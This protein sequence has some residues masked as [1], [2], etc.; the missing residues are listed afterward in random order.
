MTKIK[1]TII[2]GIGGFYYV[3]DAQGVVHECKAC[4]RFRKEN[5][6]P[7]VGDVVEFQ[8]QNNLEYGFV[9][10][11]LP[12]KNQ[13]LRPEVANIDLLMI[14]VSASTPHVDFTLCDKLLIQAEKAGI[15]Q[16]LCINKMETDKKTV[17]EMQKQYAAYDQIAVSAHERLG[18]EQFREAVRG[19][20]VCLTGQSAVGKSSIINVLD[21]SLGLQVGGLSKKTARGRH[22]TR[23]TEL[24]PISKLDALVFDTP[25]F[26]ILDVSDIPKEELGWY[27]KEFE[28]YGGH[29]KFAS[30]V[31]NK[32][33]GCAVKDAVK[34][35]KID[36]SRYDR[37]ISLLTN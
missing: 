24:L 11:I 19:K 37:Y 13:L 12:R 31:H 20:C 21:E 14:V 6:K 8:S 35:G 27:Y 17:A 26:S 10:N 32:E 22:T 3:V 23:T 30:C 36:K 29:C 16:L 7:L 25:G 28:E 4:G 5:I 9:E 15:D 34:Q 1:G 33:P 2:K 18:M